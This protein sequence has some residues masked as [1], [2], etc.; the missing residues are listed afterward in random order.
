[1]SSRIMHLSMMTAA[2]FFVTGCSSLLFRSSPAP[3][4]YQL[5]Y[6]PA[7]VNCRETFKKGVRIW[8]FSASSPY[9]QP[10]M[11]VVKPGGEVSFSSGF[12]WATV[13]GALIAQAL[14]QDFSG[15]SL[16]PQAVP[17]SGPIYAPLELT[18]HFYEFAWE[19]SDSVSHAVLKVQVSLTDS[20]RAHSVVFRKEYSLRS[21]PMAQ[22]SAAAFAGAMSG[23]VREFSLNLRQDLCRMLGSLQTS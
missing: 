23:L 11:V 1:M 5:R 10:E 18:G 19:R 14:L 6:E 20:E 8:E 7:P 21:P 9:D 17:S 12:Q 22:D 2:I 3:V 15:G 4:Y 16:F 13:P